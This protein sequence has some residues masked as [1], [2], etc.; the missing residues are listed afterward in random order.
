MNGRRQRWEHHFLEESQA[1]EMTFSDVLPPFHTNLISIIILN[2]YFEKDEAHS[3]NDLTYIILE[4]FT[5]NIVD[6]NSFMK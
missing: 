1:W 2:I 4:Y 5:N 6:T 3:V